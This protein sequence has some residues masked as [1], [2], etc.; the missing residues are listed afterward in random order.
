MRVP[1]IGHRAPVPPG[2]QLAEMVRARFTSHG[3]KLEDFVAHLTDLQVNN[4]NPR[5]GLSCLKGEIDH[6]GVR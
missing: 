3:E 6:L 2:A 1:Q 5:V 4:L